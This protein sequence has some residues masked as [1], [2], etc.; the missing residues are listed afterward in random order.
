MEPT[1]AFCDNREKKRKKG[2]DEKNSTTDSYLTVKNS[3]TDSYLTVKNSTT[4]SYLTVTV[5]CMYMY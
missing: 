2:S 1:A 4:D 5:N 3:T